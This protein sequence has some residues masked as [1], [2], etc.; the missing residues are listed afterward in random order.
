M[1]DK[2]AILEFKDGHNIKTPYNTQTK[3]PF[4]FVFKYIENSID[5]I[6]NLLLT[7]VAREKNQNLNN[8]QKKR[9]SIIG[10]LVIEHYHIYDG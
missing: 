7:C 5:T 2:Q 10:F 1:N 8:I 4:V 6:H 3:L 9:S